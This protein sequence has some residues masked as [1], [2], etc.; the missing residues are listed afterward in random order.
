MASISNVTSEKSSAVANWSKRCSMISEADVMTSQRRS[1]IGWTRPKIDLNRPIDRVRRVLAARRQNTET[2][3]L[4][5]AKI[6]CIRLSVETQPYQ[7]IIL[8]NLRAFVVHSKSRQPLAPQ[9]LMQGPLMQWPLTGCNTAAR[10]SHCSVADGI[11][12]DHNHQ[13][14]GSLFRPRSTKVGRH[15]GSSASSSRRFGRRRNRVAMAISL[16]IRASWAPRQKWKAASKVGGVHRAG[17]YP[18]ADPGYPDRL[19]GL[20]WQTPA[21]RGRSLPSGFSSRQLSSMSSSAT[22]PVNWTDEL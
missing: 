3:G 17:R 7:M 10:R 19:L 6:N 2:A 22:R 14:A 4:T 12:V 20:H 13:L 8:D 5:G 21:G 9:Y 18:A 16:S 11:Q 1:R 15:S